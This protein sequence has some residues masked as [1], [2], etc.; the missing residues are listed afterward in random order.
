MRRQHMASR[1]DFE[2]IVGLQMAGRQWRLRFTPTP[3]HLVAT[4]SLQPWLVLSGGLLF[5]GILGAF[6]L[7]VTGRTVQIENEVAQRTIE[8]RQQKAGLEKEIAARKR[9]QAEVQVLNETLEQRVSARTA[10]LQSLNQKYHSIFENAIE[11]I[12]Q[13]T[14]EGRF[15]A[16]NPAMARLLG[17]RTPEELIRERTNIVSQGYVQPELRNAFKRLLDEH[18]VVRDFQYAVYTKDGRT[19]WVSEN[20]RAVRDAQGKLLYY[21][22]SMQDVTERKRT[23]Q[24]L[25]AQHALAAVLAEGTSLAGVARGLLQVLCQT[26]EWD[27]GALWKLDPVAQALRCIEIWQAPSREFREW[28]AVSREIACAPGI[29]YPGHVWMMGQSTWIADIASGADSPRKAIAARVGLRTVV[30]LPI[31]LRDEVFS[32]IELYSA[33]IRTAESELSALFEELGGQIGQFIERKQ[34]EEKLLQAQ[35]ME[36]VGQLAAGV[37]HDF[38]NLLVV[39]QGYPQ[40]LLARKSLDPDTADSLREMMVAAEQAAKLTRQLLVFSR[41]QVLHFTVLSLNDLVG[42]L[43]KMLRRVLGEDIILESHLGADPSWINADA[44][45]VE[46]VL[47]NLAVNGR[48]AMPGGGKLVI[49]TDQL[50][51]DAKSKPNHPEARA[52][53]FVCL[54]VADTGH[55]M[56]PAVMR[57]MFEPFFTTKEVGKGT[58]LGLATV[59]GIVK[60]HDGWIE[61]ASQVGVGTTFEVYFPRATPTAALE[62]QKLQEIKARGGSETVLLVEDDPTVRRLAA[63]VLEGHGYRV[64]EARSGVEALS[65]WDEHRNVIQLLLT[66]MVM[67]DSVTG[68]ELAERLQKQKPGLKVIYTSGYPQ[69]AADAGF[70]LQEGVNFLSKPYG[71]RQLAH[72]VR[73]RLDRD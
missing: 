63:K 44:G 3:K 7:V 28:I 73:E 71:T 34:L 9:A 36:C 53:E 11:G 69:K 21:E 4:R 43:A 12:F 47:I 56:P 60:Q 70:M 41:K 42:N 33:H 19:I 13:T 8:L 25:A 2:R 50:V 61:L 37:A 72:A 67:P 23:E 62:A 35:K 38:N 58:G 48:D 65:I 29:D 45:M 5:T 54:R 40:V 22:G 55:G 18:G 1:L 49:G 24:R 6:L 52:G 20:A 32:V 10:Q 15:L 26:F 59:F 17:Y 14:P 64:L 39:L 46:Q 31:R 68:R 30:A 51:L 16:V 57:R 27:L 66:D